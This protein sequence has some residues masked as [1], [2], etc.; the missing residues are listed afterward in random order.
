ML[1]ASDL[2]RRYL[3]CWPLARR[4]WQEIAG[5]VP[6]LVVVA[7]S[8]EIPD[9]LRNDPNV[10]VFE[11]V[12]RLHTAFQAQCIRLL[13]PALLD[14]GGGVITSDVDMVPL[15]RSYF[16]SSPARIPRRH[17]LAYRDVLLFGDEIPICYNAALPGT[18]GELFQI[19]TVGDVRERLLEWADGLNYD[20]VRGGHGWGTDQIVLYRTAVDRGRRARDVWIL[21]DRYSGYHRLNTSA[22]GPSGP[23]HLL[24]KGIRR[25]EYS[26]YH[27]FHPY[28]KNREINERIVEWAIDARRLET[29]GPR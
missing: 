25:G 27:L 17:F 9:E 15:N 14:G 6:I 18:W 8:E 29:P 2:N 21:D 4:A 7:R 26:D 20:G 23:E 1:T 5:L 13:Y 22:L 24:R 28:K 3:D 11:P 19:A 10:Q 16:H 12:E